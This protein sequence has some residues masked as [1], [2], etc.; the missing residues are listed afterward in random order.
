MPFKVRAKLVAFLGDEEKYPCHFAYKI[1]DE[2]IWDGEKFTG[3]ICPYLLPELSMKVLWLF[4]A[5]P[6]YRE[7]AYYLPFWYASIS[8]KDPERKKYDGIGFKPVLKPQEPYP[9]VPAGAFQWPP[10]DERLFKDVTVVCGDTRTSALFKLEAFDLADKGDATTYFRRQM[11]IL[12]RVHRRN[13]VEVDKILDEFTEEEKYEIYP[14]LSSILV[15]MLVEELQLLNYLELKDGNAYVT[16]K[17]KAKLQNFKE[18]LS[19]VERQ[20]LKLT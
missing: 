13:A 20:A 15:K 5:G 1:G 14:P 6:R 10:V 8:L 18:S 9:G 16:N 7:S 3:R 12:D 17:G 2:I 4:S 11:V 19:E